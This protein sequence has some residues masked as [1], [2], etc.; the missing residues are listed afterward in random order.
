MIIKK[1]EEKI[2]KFFRGLKISPSIFM[3]WKNV[4]VNIK[5]N[6]IAINS[7]GKTLLPN[8]VVITGYKKDKI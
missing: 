3:F 2:N 4:I 7:N 1:I 6:K 8:T 5:K